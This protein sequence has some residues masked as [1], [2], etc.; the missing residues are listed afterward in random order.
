MHTV[1]KTATLTLKILRYSQVCLVISQ[2]YAWKGPFI[3]QVEN[4]L[5]CFW[6]YFI[7]KA[8]MTYAKLEMVTE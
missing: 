8:I 4:N 7:L 1:E 6:R 2:N 5:N 3:D